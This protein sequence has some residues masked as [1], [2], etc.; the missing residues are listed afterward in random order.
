MKKVLYW[1]V[2]IWTILAIPYVDF[3][4]FTM[5]FFGLLYIGLII[6]LMISDIRGK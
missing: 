4:T 1:I 6:G 5:A 2:L 3:S